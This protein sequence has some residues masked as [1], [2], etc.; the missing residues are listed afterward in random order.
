MG[1]EWLKGLRTG[2]GLAELLEQLGAMGCLATRIGEALRSE[3]G[4][5]SMGGDFARGA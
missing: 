3:Y 5:T 4:M 2:A 1:I